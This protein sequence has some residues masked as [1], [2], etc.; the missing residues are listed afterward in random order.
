VGRLT[1]ALIVVQAGHYPRKTGATG[2]G[3]LD[4]NPTEQEFTIA[5]A[6]ACARHLAAADHRARVIWADPPSTNAYA[7]DAFVAIHCDGSTSSSA[8]GA[9]VGYRNDPGR[10]LAARFKRAYQAAGWTGGWRPDN[11]TKALAGYYGTKR[12]VEAGTARAFIAEAG[13]LTNPGDERLLS[14][15]A[16]PER[17]A[18]ALTAA[19]VEV[20]GGHNQEDDP[21][22]ALTNEQQLELLRKVREIW[23]ETAANPPDAS[24][25]RLKD[26]TIRVRDLH[27]RATGPDDTPPTG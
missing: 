22:S 6:N 19:V 25:C 4:G 8:H 16:G 1:V 5:A 9:S 7:G 24:E 3:G 14:G 10:D 26:T 18:R 23:A 13:F 27:E 20:F 17:F 11:Y 21:L 2:T 15:T 12:A